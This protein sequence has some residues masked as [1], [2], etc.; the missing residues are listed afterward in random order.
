[1]LTSI[2]R[3]NLRTDTIVIL[4]GKAELINVINLIC[5]YLHTFI[6]YKNYPLNAE[7]ITS[8]NSSQRFIQ[9]ET[10]CRPKVLYF[11]L[12]ILIKRLLFNGKKGYCF[13]NL[14]FTIK[15]MLDLIQAENILNKHHLLANNS[16]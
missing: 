3:L 8:V 15:K 10:I 5:Y 4:L 9:E 11:I 13:K 12:E 2:N 1:M 16:L 14:L 7:R 6:R